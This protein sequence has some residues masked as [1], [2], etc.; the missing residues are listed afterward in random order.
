MIFFSGG[1]LIRKWTWFGWLCVTECRSE[2]REVR[3]NLQLGRFLDF[4][5]E[6]WRVSLTGSSVLAEG[7]NFLSRFLF[8]ERWMGLSSWYS[9]KW[10]HYDGQWASEWKSLSCV[11]LSVTLWWTIRS[12]EFSRPDY[13]GFPSPGNLPNP[14]I[15]P[16]TPPLQADSLPAESHRGS[17]WWATSP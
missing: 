6:Y 15:E 14:G 5:K 8:E 4:I 7:R 2:K 1:I 3:R 9:I 17:P 10:W 11:W 16:R 13:W 12:M